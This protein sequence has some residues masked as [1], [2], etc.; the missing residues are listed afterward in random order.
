MHARVSL[1]LFSQREENFGTILVTLKG[2]IVSSEKGILEVVLRACIWNYIR[3]FCQTP[4]L[5]YI[6][7]WGY[8]F[9]I[10]V[11]TEEHFINSFVI[12]TCLPW[13]RFRFRVVKVLESMNSLADICILEYGKKS[14]CFPHW[15]INRIRKKNSTHRFKF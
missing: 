4:F 9:Q 1:R 8:V 10:S 15:K 11:L 2:R 3:I 6:I 7:L 5:A 14:T 13:N 12:G